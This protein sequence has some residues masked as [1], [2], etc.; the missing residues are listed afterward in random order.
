[1]ADL[2]AALARK[3]AIEEGRPVSRIVRTRKPK[4]HGEV[5]MTDISVFRDKLVE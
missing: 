3:Q 4:P 5:A 1:V 2:K